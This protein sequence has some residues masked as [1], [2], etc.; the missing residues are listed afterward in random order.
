VRSLLH[1][2]FA[3]LKFCSIAK[4][5]KLKF[6]V[7]VNPNS[8]PGAAPWWPNEDYVRELPR[9]NAYENVQVVGY[10][11][12]T[13]CKRAIEHVFDD[14]QV[15]A[16]RCRDEPAGL[17]VQGIFLDETTNVYSPL[18]K[19]YLGQIDE[20]VKEMNGI[21]G[22]KIVCEHLCSLRFIS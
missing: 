7:I 13:Y 8:G 1:R 4:N 5:P 3:K 6:L 22:D 15:Y 18:V 19:E 17:G 2:L 14:I 20:K 21:G 9:L 16:D 11:R 12:A 10:V